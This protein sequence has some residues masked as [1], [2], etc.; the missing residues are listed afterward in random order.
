LVYL[1]TPSAVDVLIKKPLS[2]VSLFW[3]V[4]EC[5]LS[6]RKKIGNSTQQF[7]AKL[8]RKGEEVGLMQGELLVKAR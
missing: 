8:M 5:V 2:I 6:L 4:G 3:N 7:E 1:F